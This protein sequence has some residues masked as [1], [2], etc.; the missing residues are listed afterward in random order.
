[1]PQKTI[2]A[3]TGVTIRSRH[4]KGRQA[5]SSPGAQPVR[6]PEE[7]A[8]RRLQLRTRLLGWECGLYI[9]SGG[10]C[11]NAGV[12]S[13]R[14][15]HHRRQLEGR[16]AGEGLE[17]LSGPVGSDLRRRAFS[18]WRG[19]KRGGH[20]V[21]LDSVDLFN[22]IE[23]LGL[24][25][26]HTQAASNLTAARSRAFN[27]LLPVLKPLGRGGRSPSTCAPGASAITPR[28]PR[29]TW[30]SILATAPVARRVVAPR[31]AKTPRPALE[32]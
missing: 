25:L 31:S 23:A 16:A 32:K 11:P 13:Q 3:T 19:R 27:T 30:N 14:G 28:R 24:L 21:S 15:I 9:G 5:R 26:W 1:M 7:T 18:G 17:I 4:C 8:P 12:P 20:S 29:S 2:C 6:A 10:S 22:L